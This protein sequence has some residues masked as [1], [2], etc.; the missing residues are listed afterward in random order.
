MDQRLI[1]WEELFD[2][3]KRGMMKQ[4]VVESDAEKVADNLVQSN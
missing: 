1:N 4:N 2:F 3:T